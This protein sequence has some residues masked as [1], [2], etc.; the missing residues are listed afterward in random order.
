[1]S[2]YYSYNDTC[3]CEYSCYADGFAFETRLFLVFSFGRRK[4]YFF[5]SIDFL[6]LL[7]LLPATSDLFIPVILALHVL[8]LV[9]C[10][11]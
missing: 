4:N 9:V 6:L 7:F 11:V 2:L 1:M 3:G 5:T 8:Y 10:C